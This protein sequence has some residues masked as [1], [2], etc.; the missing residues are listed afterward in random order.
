MLEIKQLTRLQI[1]RYCEK[2][3]DRVKFLEEENKILNEKIKNM[4]K[5]EKDFMYIMKKYILNEWNL[6]KLE[7]LYDICSEW[8]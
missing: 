7:T 1:I 8:K 2:L 6:K 4:E 3:E 5:A